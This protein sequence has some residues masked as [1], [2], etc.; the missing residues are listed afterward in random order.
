MDDAALTWL[1][2]KRKHRR[3]TTKGGIGM[4]K[5]ALEVSMTL[6]ALALLLFSM[7]FGS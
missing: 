1:V 6:L 4:A 3:P 2:S 7:A 5:I